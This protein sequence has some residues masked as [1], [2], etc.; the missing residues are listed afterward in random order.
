[1]TGDLMV[2]FLGRIGLLIM[3]Y[4]GF[5]GAFTLTCLMLITDIYDMAC[6]SR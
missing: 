1:L 6:L 5:W 3:I 4:F 2:I